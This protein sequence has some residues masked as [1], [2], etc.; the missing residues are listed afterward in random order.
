MI[1]KIIK[2]KLRYNHKRS[3]V[4]IFMAVL[5]CSL[6]LGYAMLST[7]L[8]IE[9]TS[10]FHEANWDVHFE[11]IQVKNG[12]ITPTSPATITN[13]T[14]VTFN[15]KLEN[16]NDFYEFTVDVVNSGTINAMVGGINILPVLTSAQQEY[17]DYKVTYK[18][19]KEIE[20]KQ[21]L[22][23]GTAETIKVHFS[24]KENVDTSLYPT[25]DQDIPITVNIEYV[26]KEDD[27]TEVSPFKKCTYQGTLTQGSEFIEGPYTY[28]YKQEYQ[29]IADVAQWANIETDG[30]GVRITDATSTAPITEE[31]CTF[32]ND[33]P[34]VS[35]SRMFHGAQTTSVDFSKFNTRYVTN[36]SEM[37]SRAENITQFDLSSF[38]TSNVTNMDGM[39]FRVKA[40]TI[41]VTS[42]D[43]SKVIYMSSMFHSVEVDTLDLSSFDT[44]QVTQMGTMFSY[45]NIPVVDV[46]SFDTSNVTTMTSMFS[47][48]GITT[49][50]FSDK[51]KTTSVTNMDLMFSNTPINGTLDLSSFDMTN[52]S[53]YNYIFL[54]CTAT[55]VYVRSSVEQNKLN[56]SSGKPSGMSI[57]IKS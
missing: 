22:D 7:Q 48:S 31:P 12:S 1:W 18:N 57:V 3:I 52:I 4:F 25:E 23:A 26:Q 32:I 9:G 51:F 56:N 44:S 35:M 28:H 15:V 14:T 13:P 43:T 6:G 54:N 24:Y 47:E 5:A 21:Q 46:S 8:S 49:V 38:D 41:D 11:N 2:L 30:W 33:K 50:I 42:F 20:L 10:K 55:T 19:N 27:A 34:I 37:F 17:L 36:M 45:S 16:P 53:Y 40:Q 39:F 29:K